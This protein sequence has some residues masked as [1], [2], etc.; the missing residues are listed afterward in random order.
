MNTTDPNTTLRPFCPHDYEAFAGVT[1]DHPQIAN[2]RPDQ[3]HWVVILD[4]ARIAL[5]DE[6]QQEH[7][8]TYPDDCLSEEAAEMMLDD[9]ATG[10]RTDS[11]CAA[12]R[13]TRTTQDEPTNA[14]NWTIA[15]RFRADTAAAC[16]ASHFARG[17]V[18]KENLTTLANDA[19][20]AADALIAALAR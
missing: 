20:L 17:P 3:D 10:A 13:L 19:V 7:A 1:S 2:S 11:V 6:E 15:E 14:N 8:R 5:Y 4:G 9:L 18:F 12:Y 16:M